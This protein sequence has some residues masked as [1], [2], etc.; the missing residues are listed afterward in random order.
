MHIWDFH[1]SSI[2]LRVFKFALKLFFNFSFRGKTCR[3]ML[4][5]MSFSWCSSHLYP[6]ISLNNFLK[7]LNN[8]TSLNKG[9]INHDGIWISGL[10]LH[11]LLLWFYFSLFFLVFVLVNWLT[12][13]KIY[14]LHFQA[15]CHLSK[16]LCW[17]LIV[18]NFL[19]L[20]LVFVV[21]HSLSGLIYFFM[22]W[23]YAKSDYLVIFMCLF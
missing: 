3:T 20:F 5:R 2:E 16:I 8:S 12:I 14:H 21:K 15:F 23:W 9:N 6:G 19:T 18:L 10:N 17:V 22:I 4:Y 13:F 11:W 7:L 1:Y